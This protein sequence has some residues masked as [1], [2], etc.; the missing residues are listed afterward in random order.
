MGAGPAAAGLELVDLVLHQR[1]E[2]RDDQGR[3]GQ[4][5]SGQL[6]AEG[7]SPGMRVRITENNSKRVRFW[8]GDEEHLLAPIVAANISAIPLPD[9]QKDRPPMPW[10]EDPQG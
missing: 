6:V 5:Q 2:R 4:K 3:A 10:E 8:I 1:D 7:L 9:E